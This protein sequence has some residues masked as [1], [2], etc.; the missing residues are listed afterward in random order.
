MK[1]NNHSLK[2]NIFHEFSK[3]K[4]NKSYH[5][6]TQDTRHK[7]SLNPTTHTQTKWLKINLANVWISS[8]KKQPNPQLFGQNIKKRSHTNFRS[9]F[10]YN[11]RILWNNQRKVLR[12]KYCG[13][14][15]LWPGTNVLRKNEFNALIYRIQNMNYSWIHTL[16][17]L[18]QDAHQ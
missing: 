11:V 4:E 12:E 6:S 16:K 18:L 9:D 13:P 17:F 3:N 7:G 1:L 8:L 14:R 5:L 10:T 2:K 15:I